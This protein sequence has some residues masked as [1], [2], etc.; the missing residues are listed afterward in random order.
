LERNS[1]FTGLIDQTFFQLPAYINPSFQRKERVFLSNY[2]QRIYYLFQKF[3]VDP[4]TRLFRVYRKELDHHLQIEKPKII[5]I[6]K[7]KPC[8]KQGFKQLKNRDYL[9]I[10]FLEI[11]L[12]LFIR[13]RPGVNPEILND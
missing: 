10:N 3:P 11:P 1:F 12:E 7:K 9:I 4:K 8:H 5:L 13:Y 2:V 6:L